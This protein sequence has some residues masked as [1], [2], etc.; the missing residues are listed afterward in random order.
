MFGK[1]Q[2]TVIRFEGNEDD[3]IWSKEILDC[4]FECEIVADA[5]WKVVYLKNGKIMEDISGDRL[6]LNSSTL[7]KRN[8]EVFD[9]KVFYVNVNNAFT[10]KWGTKQQTRVIDGFF[11][12]PIS[13]GASGTFK[14]TVENAHKLVAKLCAARK[15]LTNEAIQTFFSNE[16]TM[17]VMQTLTREVASGRTNAYNLWANAA[18]V[19]ESMKDAIK[20]I[21][22]DYGI[23]ITGF[24]IGAIVLP[25]ED[26][27][28]FEEILRKKRLLEMKESSFREEEAKQQAERQAN[29]DAM[30]KLAEIRADSKPQTVINI[31]DSASKIKFCPYCGA[32]VG[33][34]AFCSACG[35]KLQ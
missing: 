15:D 26:I 27:Q 28:Q 10:I 29:Y 31:G 22:E 8:Q 2:K 23:K 16:M 7:F 1:K 18:S 3:L 33:E 24:S 4:N 11:Y 14:I 21:F 17:Y 34:G 12:F 32:K 30:V 5:F 20:D 35:K 19:A 9:I 13:I 6:V 25:R